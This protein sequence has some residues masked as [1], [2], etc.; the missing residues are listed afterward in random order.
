[1]HSLR[2]PSRFARIQLY[3]KLGRCRC[4]ASF[5]LNP[6][7]NETGW[8]TQLTG[9]QMVP[10]IVSRPGECILMKRGRKLRRQQMSLF[11]RQVKKRERQVKR[12]ELKK[13]SSSFSPLP[14]RRKNSKYTL[15]CWD[16]E[17]QHGAGDCELACCVVDA[18]SNPSEHPG[19][20]LVK[21]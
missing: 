12:L 10:S 8:F 1:M 17:I 16:L 6:E 15:K 21:L 3:R 2:N 7:E 19:F 9:R 5:L 13:L 14:N 20:S 18:G 4:F 11:W